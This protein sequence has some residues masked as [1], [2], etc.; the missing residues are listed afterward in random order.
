MFPLGKPAQEAWS[1]DEQ[2][3]INAFDDL[4]L[5]WI[6]MHTKS[7]TIVVD[8]IGANDADVK[9]LGS[10][11]GFAFGI[12]VQ[13]STLVTAGQSLVVSFSDYYAAVKVQ[14]KSAVANTPTQVV[15]S[16]SAIAV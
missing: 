15:A 14:I 5:P 1:A 8:N 3:T 2:S 9:V 11:N 12:Q 7:G 10:V 4:G 13:Q 16:G 6:K